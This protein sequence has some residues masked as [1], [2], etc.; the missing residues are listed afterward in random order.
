M[1]EDM[2]EMFQAMKEASQEK[3]AGN[4]ENGPKV[5]MQNGFGFQIKNN[6]AHIIVDRI[7]NLDSENNSLKYFVDYWP[8]TGKWIFRKLDL[9]GRGVFNLV[10]KLKELNGGKHDSNSKKSD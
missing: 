9:N 6:G 4:R 7:K 2:A 5:L 1:S 10:K 3:R 8:G